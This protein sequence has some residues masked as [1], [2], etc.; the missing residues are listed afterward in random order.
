VLLRVL[1]RRVFVVLGGVQG[2][3]MGHL[4]VVRGLFV[5]APLVVFGGLAMVL[6]RVLM[7]VRSFL[8]VFMDVMTGH[9]AL[10]G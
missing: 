10:P 9:C 3:P 1:F 7:V 4:G 2:M 8:V 6:C 5:I